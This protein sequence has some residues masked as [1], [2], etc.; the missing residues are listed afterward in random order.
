[1]NEGLQFSDYH[2]T[3]M[4][5]QLLMYVFI[6]IG[7]VKMAYAKNA[8]AYWAAAIFPILAFG[9]NFGLRWGRGIDYN[10]Y[11]WIYNDILINTLY[12]DVEPLWHFAVIIA[13]NVFNLPWH[14]MVMFMSFFLIFSIVFFVKNHREI[15]FYA[16]PLFALNVVQSQ[17]LMRW[18]FAC[19]FFFI[20]LKFLEEKNLK[21]FVIFS[22]C[23]FFIH[24]GFIIVMLPIFLLHYYKKPLLPPWISILIFLLLYFLFNRD[25]MVFLADFI[26][27]LNLASRF[28]AYQRNAEIWLTGENLTMDKISTINVVNGIYILIFGYR[29]I[30]K[31]TNLTFLYNVTLV[32]IITS[33]A[34]SQV[35]LMWRINLIFISFQSLLLAYLFRD[36]I[37]LRRSRNMIYCM[38]TIAVLLLNV[39]TIVLQPLAVKKTST[40]YI[41]DSKGRNTLN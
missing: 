18:F 25:D 11:Y 20:A 17:N 19:S 4:G 2:L 22:C 35:E 1:M 30:K 13:G 14:G 39:K 34:M 40:Y 32:G 16:L 8:K 38:I 28:V 6:I 36:L 24:F 29:M 7:G 41:W 12:H 9:L 3:Y 33:P 21:K 23:A 31:R 10:L 5:C 15:A 26:R 37:N 27:N